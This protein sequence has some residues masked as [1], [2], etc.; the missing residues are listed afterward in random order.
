MVSLL[1]LAEIT[2]EG[3]KFK[4]PYDGKQFYIVLFA[5]H[6]SGCF[7]KMVIEMSFIQAVSAY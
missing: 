7:I 5:H 2:E 1:E 3:V 6:P 4:S